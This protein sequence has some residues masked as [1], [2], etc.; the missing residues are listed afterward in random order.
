M[1]VKQAKVE[2]TLRAVA[3]MN[4]DNFVS[5][6]LMDDFDGTIEKARFVPWDYD[7]K[8]D[9]EVLAVALTIKP[10]DADAPFV[11]HYSAGDMTGFAPSM[12]GENPVNLEGEGEEREG[13]YA[14]RVGK[15]NE[16]RSSTNWA[17]F[18]E[19]L[20]A[21]GF[22]RAKM[23]PSLEFM[24]GLN[25]HFNR[26]PQKKRSGIQ[27]T[28]R[29]DGRARANDVL[30]I[31]KINEAAPAAAKT[32]AKAAK[33]AAAKAAATDDGVEDLLTGVI[34]DALGENEGQIAKSKLVGLILKAISG[35][36][37]AR[38]IKLANDVKW[39]SASDVW[40]FD[41]ESGTLTLA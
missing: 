38:A 14:L 26:V 25:C 7:G 32:G 24:E 8:I 20:V 27:V 40:V 5:G 12:D 33:P 21:A 6:G 1:A 31:T 10:D 4:P 28:T 22:D 19:A 37:R 2:K 36:D 41:A 30:V 23:T 34:V 9:H 39:L 35:A 17:H 3:S 15:Q 13:I 16:L 18:L 11:Q 29:E